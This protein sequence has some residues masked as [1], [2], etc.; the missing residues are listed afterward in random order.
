MEHTRKNQE[1]VVQGK[2]VGIVYYLMVMLKTILK[3]IT[4]YV[5]FILGTS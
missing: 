1:R 3:Y 4:Y 2:I 5:K